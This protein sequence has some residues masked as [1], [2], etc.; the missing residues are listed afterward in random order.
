MICHPLT[1]AEK[2]HSRRSKLSRN[3]AE[4][5]AGSNDQQLLSLRKTLRGRRLL[6]RPQRTLLGFLVDPTRKVP[7]RRVPSH[8]RCPRLFL[9]ASTPVASPRRLR[10]QRRLLVV[11][12][13]AHRRE[14]TQFGCALA[15]LDVTSI[16]GAADLAA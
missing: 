14:H 13:R 5:Y 7:V 16:T 15:Q 3:G 4:G 9:P 10:P 2:R 8:Q 12:R 11:R 6:S 1:T